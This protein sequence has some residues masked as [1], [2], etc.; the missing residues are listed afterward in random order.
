MCVHGQHYITR[1]TSTSDAE[2]QCNFRK[3]VLFG[4]TTAFNCFFWYLPIFTGIMTY[5]V[6]LVTCTQCWNYSQE[7]L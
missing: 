1:S 7:R 4:N 6:S 5:N 2:L 3:P